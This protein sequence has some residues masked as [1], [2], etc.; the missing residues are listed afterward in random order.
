MRLH[1]EALEALEKLHFKVSPDWRIC[2]SI[3]EVKKFIDSW[4]GKREK[5]PYEI[6]GIVIKVN[7]IALQQELG[8]HSE[9]AAMGG[10]IQIS[11]AAG[12]HRRERRH[13]SGGAHG[14][15]HAGGRARAGA[16][17]R[18]HG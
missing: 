14:N 13:F 9:G 15:P 6:D 10:R 8:L 4:E 12:N 1:S 3:D 17:R 16:S 7:E 18:R 11:R 2:H 5:L